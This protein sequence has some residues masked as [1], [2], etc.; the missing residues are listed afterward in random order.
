MKTLSLAIGAGETYVRDILKRERQPS[1]DR[2]SKLASALGVSVAWLSAETPS[3]EG[4]ATSGFNY[5]GKYAARVVGDIAYDHWLGRKRLD[6]YPGSD[7]HKNTSLELSTLDFEYGLT[8]TDTSVNQIANVGDTLLCEPTGPDYS[9]SLLGALV[10]VERENQS[11]KAVEITARRVVEREG[12]P[13]LV[14]ASTDTRLTDVI[15]IPSDDTEIVT[16]IVGRVVGRI[17]RF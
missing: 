15:R 11:T 14:F 9:G 5:L 3:I 1:H 17:E 4:P 7:M 2:F 16:R 13:A 8:V 12:A 6:K 10:I